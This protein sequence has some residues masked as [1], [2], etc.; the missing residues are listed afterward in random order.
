[1]ISSSFEWLSNFISWNFYS[2]FESSYPLL[3]SSFSKVFILALCLSCSYLFTRFTLFRI[4]ACSILIFFS[5]YKILDFSSEISW[6]WEFLSSFKDL[7][8]SSLLLI[9]SNLLWISF[10]LC[11]ISDSS[12]FICSF[13]ISFYEVN[14]RFSTDI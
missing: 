8:M 5:Y 6:F 13:R 3:E 9:I 4:S 2:T 10:L 7:S 12:T 11:S 1:M 14:L